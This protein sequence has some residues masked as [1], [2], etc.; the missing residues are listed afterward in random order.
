MAP[1]RT[2]RA[3]CALAALFCLLL[4]ACEAGPDTL[5]RDNPYDIESARYRPQLTASAVHHELEWVRIKWDEDLPF[6]EG[7]V[8][9]RSLNGADFV[10]IA[11]L[12]GSATS[13]KDS[14]EAAGSYR[15]RVTRQ[16]M[17]GRSVQATTNALTI[18]TWFESGRRNHRG[19]EQEFA[20]ELPDARI[21]V[22][23]TQN[24]Y[25]GP[26]TAEIL[27][28]ATLTWRS[29][30][31]VPLTAVT[32]VTTL[33]D[34]RVLALGGVRR[35]YY[36]YLWDEVGGAIFDPAR[37]EWSALPSVPYPSAD[38]ILPFAVVHL[39]GDDVL[40][41]LQAVNWPGGYL[42]PET[43]TSVV[44]VAYVLNLRTGDVREIDAPEVGGERTMAT[45]TGAGRDSAGSV[46]VFGSVDCERG[47]CAQGRC[48]WT[49]DVATETWTMHCPQSS[50]HVSHLLPFGEGR[51]LS[52]MDHATFVLDDGPTP[53]LTTIP[54]GGGL[55]Y[56]E[57][58]D[59]Y[60]IG[61]RNILVIRHGPIRHRSYPSPYSYSGSIAIPLPSGR[62][63]VTSQTSDFVRISRVLDETEQGVQ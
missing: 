37:L 13:H 57:I 23:K 47:Q 43:I 56:L 62:F 61:G 36:A 3:T 58:E 15:Y 40:V 5:V 41:S 51:F 48:N 30:P 26:A 31:P 10:E 52:L 33:D 44:T 54:S 53:R 38:V 27:D 49:F 19:S 60:V 39:G 45:V 2:C 1:S 8:I 16:V 20:V 4:V 11:R 34:G 29:V 63:L 14:T 22:F 12:D 32:S 18:G 35:D 55:A 9:E 28:T 25:S 6:N 21:L 59:G 46:R 42:A 7:F 17:G 24:F 50:P